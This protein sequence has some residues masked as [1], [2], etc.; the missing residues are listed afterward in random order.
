MTY[1]YTIKPRRHPG[2]EPA[3]DRRAEETK[4]D[5][6]MRDIAKMI[7]HSLLKPN[8]TDGDVRRG[9]EVAKKY[10]V[11]SVCCGPSQVPLV[12][13]CLEG[14][15]VLVSTVIGFPH[16]YSTTAVKVFEAE[17][18]MASGAVELDMVLNI[19]KLLSRDFEYAKRDVES[20]CAAAH[21]KGC[22]VKV[23]LENAYL[24]DE[25]K[26]AAC[27]LCE[28][29][30][31]DFVKTSTGFAPSGATFK[32]LRLMRGA[33]SPR[34]RVKAAGGIRELDTALLVREVGAARFGATA[35]ESIMEECRA[36]TGG[37]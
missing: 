15:D 5:Y 23:I 31:A 24:T 32:D 2:F 29:A 20:V 18:A 10:H 30:G 11:A 14:S 27:E 6:S 35:T 13:E 37:R 33:V 8:L 1:R 28:E 36:R 34:V 3:I 9:C 26:V 19:S 12:K 16:G 7:D 22:I 25:L 21:A 4:V 17:E